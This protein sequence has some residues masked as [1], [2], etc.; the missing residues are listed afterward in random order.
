MSQI[1]PAHGLPAEFVDLWATTTTATVTTLSSSGA[2]QTTATWFLVEDGTIK[3]S[4]EP[5]KQKVRNLL[6]DPRCTVMILDPTDP[7]RSLEIR[8]VATV[9]H[10]PGLE[11]RHRVGAQYGFPVADGSPA[12]VVVTFTPEKIRG[13]DYRSCDRVAVARLFLDCL[14]VQRDAAASVALV[15]DDF[16]S[17]DPNIDGR[18]G[19][20]H[21]VEWLNAH[22]QS[23]HMKVHHEFISGDLV[24]I[25]HTDRHGDSAGL[26]AVDILRIV[27]GRITEY[28]GVVGANSVAA[29]TPP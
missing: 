29:D 12:H 2:P 28:W 3:C 23:S 15:S 13:S 27:D 24:A 11:F 14:V 25:H 21:F 26:A 18:E 16:I 20:V 19:L 4:W 10:D 6:Q 22:H 17:H 8:A 1:D 7:L 5:T 9:A